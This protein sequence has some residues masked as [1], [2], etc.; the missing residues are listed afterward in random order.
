[1]AGGD[2][3]PYTL[4]LWT[5]NHLSLLAGC[6][7]DVHLLFRPLVIVSGLAPHPVT[8]DGRVYQACNP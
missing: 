3:S 7:E 5:I 8:V 1:M 2:Y 6:E 4:P